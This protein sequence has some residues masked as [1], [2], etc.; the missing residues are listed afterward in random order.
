MATN[1]TDTDAANDAR[2][3]Y[4][5][6]IAILAAV[7]V[8]MVATILWRHHSQHNNTPA[9]VSTAS[10]ST[11]G[12]ALPSPAPASTQ[13]GYGSNSAPAQQWSDKGCNGHDSSANS[14]APQLSTGIT[15]TPFLTAAIP[16]SAT[17][18]PTKVSGDMRH[19]FA[20]SPAGAVMAATVYGME[21]FQ[22][23]GAAVIKDRWTPGPGRDK[24]LSDAAS[25]E[26]GPGNMAG[27]GFAG[28]NPDR[29]NVQVSAV[30][31]GQYSSGVVPM[32]WQNGDWY[33]DGS[34]ATP[35]GTVVTTLP[36]GLTQWGPA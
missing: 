23:D 25:S 5:W 2:S 29:C 26:G 13:P 31:G 24:A 16:S 7:L 32:I 15:W 3:R 20:H 4:Y 11:T 18:G 6:I 12:S 27:Y 9:A 35:D 17:L 21:M 36:A 10:A 28:C 14:T 30:A 34:V 8:G 19:C 1:E 22:S 33:V